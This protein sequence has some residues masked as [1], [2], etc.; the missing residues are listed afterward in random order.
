MKASEKWRRIANGTGIDKGGD[1]CHLCDKFLVSSSDNRHCQDCPI[2]R[3]S[4]LEFCESTPYHSWVEHQVAQH[5]PSVW[6][7]KGE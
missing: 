1:N 5:Q 2:F 3:E 4:K 6:E 7:W